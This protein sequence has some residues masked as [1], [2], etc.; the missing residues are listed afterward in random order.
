MP[1][2]VRLTL[3]W[4]GTTALAVT[5]SWFGV[6]L[7]LYAAV[8]DRA[9]PLSVA[10]LKSASPRAT[11]PPPAAGTT[12]SPSPQPTV[13]TSNEASPKPQTWED[14][15]GLLNYLST[16]STDGGWAKIQWNSNKVIVIDAYPETGYTPEV[17]Q[18]SPTRVQISFNGPGKSTAIAAWWDDGE[19]QLVVDNDDS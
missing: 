16:V 18:L 1:R 13:Q 3:L 17:K 19:P 6:R 12:R 10:E 2:A 9:K 11:G 8:P 7:V 15:D 14:Q 5:V 4:L